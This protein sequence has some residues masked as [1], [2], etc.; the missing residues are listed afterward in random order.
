MRE[1]VSGNISGCGAGKSS[2]SS[3]SG[4]VRMP[5]SRLRR[6]SPFFDLAH[7]TA[8]LDT[9]AS[10]A[11]LPARNVVRLLVPLMVEPFL[12]V[13]AGVAVYCTFSFPASIYALHEASPQDFVQSSRVEPISNDMNNEF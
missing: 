13:Q 3:Q 9:L 12:E 5:G 7:C 8:S 10:S 11:V 6:A 4:A 1:G 2:H